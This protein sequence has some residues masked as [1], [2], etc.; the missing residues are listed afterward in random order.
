MSNF[1][2]TNSTPDGYRALNMSELQ[3][4]LQ[5]KE[6]M[7]QIVRLNEKF[8]ELQVDRAI[9]LTSNR[10]LAEESIARRP[11]LNNGKLQLAEKYKELANL[12]TICWEKQSRL[13]P[14]TQK[15]SLQ[16]AQNLLHEDVARAEEQ[17]EDL[18]EKFMEG[19]VPLE[20][21]LDSFQSSRKSYHI[22]RVQAEKIQELSRAKENSSKPKKLEEREDKAREVK[23]DEHLE[24]QQ[25]NGFVAQGP[26]RV[27]QLRYGLTPAILLPHFPLP[28]TLPSAPSHASLPPLDSQPGQTHILSPNAQFSGHGHPVNLRVIGQLPGGWPTRPVRLQQLYRP[29]THQPEPLYR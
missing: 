26:P 23:R 10:S 29:A 7:D 16:T 8:Q 21:F 4:L 12:A 15:H 18:L 22:R 11:R 17:S 6:K 28:T 9:L 5:D 24:T 14:H 27:F 1:K 19:N 13:V 20:G 2:D 3:E 25:P